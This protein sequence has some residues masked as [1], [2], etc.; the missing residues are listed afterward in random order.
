MIINKDSIV[1]K[2]NY[3]KLL[4]SR[5][6]LKDKMLTAESHPNKGIYCGFDPTASSLHL[7]HLCTLN[8]LV[9]ASSLGYT[10]IVILGTATA[11]IGDPSGK[12]ESRLLIEKDL[13]YSNTKSLSTQIMNIYQN[14]LIKT[15]QEN[16][17]LQIIENG[18]FYEKLSLI[19]FLREVGLHFPINPLLNRD[20]IEKRNDGITYTEFSYSLLQAFDFLM[21]FQ[22]HNCIGQIGGSDQ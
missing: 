3:Y 14:L 7:G 2:M 12:S 4:K 16:N 18:I 20:F 13:I 19:D 15:G 8:S 21:L 11:Q 22:H 6:L 1:Y 5:Y 9:Y 10:P 17:T